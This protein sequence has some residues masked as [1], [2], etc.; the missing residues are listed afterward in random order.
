LLYTKNLGGIKTITEVDVNTAFDNLENTF[1][2]LAEIE[3]KQQ[4]LVSDL[5]EYKDGSRKA[6]QIKKKLQEMHPKM[7]EAQRA[8]RLAGMRADRIKLLLDVEKNAKGQD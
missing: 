4:E 3:D 1:K 7:Q 5:A 6:D 2:K 8:F